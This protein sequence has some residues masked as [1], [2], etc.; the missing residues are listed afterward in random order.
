MRLPG[1]DR[2]SVG[3]LAVAEGVLEQDPEGVG[4][5]LDALERKELVAPARNCERGRGH[6][7]DST[8][9]A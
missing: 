2:P 7:V 9:T 8:E 5:A 1:Q 6:G 4:Q 3:V